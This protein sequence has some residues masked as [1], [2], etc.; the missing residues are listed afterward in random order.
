MTKP[1]KDPLPFTKSTPGDGGAPAGRSSRTVK[2]NP[3]GGRHAGA[4]LADP[5]QTLEKL[6]DRKSPAGPAD[7]S[8][9]VKR[10]DA[11]FLRD[12]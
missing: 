12:D 7:S 2:D 9:G 3:A 11:A 1:E 6:K 10:S 8:G 5:L 4:L